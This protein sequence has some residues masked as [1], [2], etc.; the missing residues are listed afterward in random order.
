MKNLWAAVGFVGLFAAG[1]AQAGLLPGNALFSSYITGSPDFNS[2]ALHTP[3]AVLGGSPAA[4][5]FTVSLAATLESL[6]L[7][8]SDPTPS[9]GG[10][11]LVYLVPN[12]TNLS[13]NIPSSTG[14]QLTG[15]TLLGT[16]FDSGLTTTHSD[17][18]MP[19]YASLTAGTYWIALVNGSDTINGGSNSS[20]T[21]ALWWRTADLIGLDIGNNVG[22]TDSGLYNAHVGPNGASV[23]TSVT[24]NSFE[25][26]IDTPEPAS[27]ALLGAGVTGLGF[28]RRRQTKRSAG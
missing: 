27:L 26:Q 8:L 10:S 15:D 18:V 1:S 21:N 2:V 3:G 17:I 20:S 19:I 23:I 6:T 7:R 12:N 5:E 22:N 14:L 9:D 13:L 11:L 28:L 4:Q 16:I 24:G 25:M